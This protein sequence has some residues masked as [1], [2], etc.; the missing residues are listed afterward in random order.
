NQTGE[1]GTGNS[2]G[3]DLCAGAPCSKAPVPVSGLS[4]VM[5]LTAGIQDS[6]SQA[7]LSNGTVKAWGDNIFGELGTGSSAGPNTCNGNPCA[8]SP[9][10]VSGLSG[11][12]EVAA[13]WNHSL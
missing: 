2:T 4:G 9:V 7:L 3:P 12:V 1:L 6:H 13:G 5:A 10:P 11:V 8:N